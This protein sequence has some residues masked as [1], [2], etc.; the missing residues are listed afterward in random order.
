MDNRIAIIIEKAKSLS[1]Q[2]PHT[3]RAMSD[4]SN[5][6][7]QA[8]GSAGNCINDLLDI[9]ESLHNVLEKHRRFHSKV[10]CPQ[11]PDCDSC[12]A[13][14]LLMLYGPTWYAAY[15]KSN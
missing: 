1:N 15:I 8:L 9:V 11:R 4:L 7:K 5:D 13:E 2:M 6:E 10:A 14:E 3:V 12:L